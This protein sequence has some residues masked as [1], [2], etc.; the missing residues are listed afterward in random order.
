MT[1]ACSSAKPTAEVKAHWNNE[2]VKD[3][4]RRDRPRG[5]WP[6]SERCRM[7]AGQ[8]VEWRERWAHFGDVVEWEQ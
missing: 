7:L 4:W 2:R 3:S 5:Y 1:H 8:E 6:Q